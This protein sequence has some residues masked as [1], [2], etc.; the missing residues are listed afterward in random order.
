MAWAEASEPAMC[1]PFSLKSKPK[2]GCSAYCCG[3]KRGIGSGV[4][5]QKLEYF[6]GN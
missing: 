4:H 2:E 3:E 6:E 1:F 5:V